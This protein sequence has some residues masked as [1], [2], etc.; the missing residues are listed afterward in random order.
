MRTKQYG[1]GDY[2]DLSKKRTI[3]YQGICVYQ[4]PKF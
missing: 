3:E 4:H 2:K 1:A